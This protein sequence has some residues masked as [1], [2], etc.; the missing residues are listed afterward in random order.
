MNYCNICILCFKRKYLLMQG[1]LQVSVVLSTA[2]KRAG[3]VVSPSQPGLTSVALS[4]SRAINIIKCSFLCT[5]EWPQEVR[6]YIST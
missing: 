3:K 5:F 4:R 1:N 6:V 2:V